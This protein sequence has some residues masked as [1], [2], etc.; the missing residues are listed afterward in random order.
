LLLNNS[1]I[2]LLPPVLVTTGES[3]SRDGDAYQHYEQSDNESL[4]SLPPDYVSD[5]IYAPGTSEVSGFLK[6]R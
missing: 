1:T 5:P 6:K 2:A 4:H 3:G